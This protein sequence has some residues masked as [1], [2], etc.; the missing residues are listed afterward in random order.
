MK[1][2]VIIILVLVNVGLCY[3]QD[4]E[5]LSKF[6]Y[7]LPVME[8]MELIGKPEGDKSAISNNIEIA[9]NAKVLQSK[10]GQNVSAEKIGKF[11]YDHFVSLKF[12]AWQKE[13]ALSGY[14]YAPDLVTQGD[15][16][17]RSQG[18]ISFWILTEG[19]SITF[20]DHLPSAEPVV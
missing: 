11:Y 8:G 18:H 16:H 12:R 9:I 17:I 10:T 3:G 13:T 14:Y 6:I 5:T 15:A 20:Y 7:S 4:K 2:Q 1:I 19:N